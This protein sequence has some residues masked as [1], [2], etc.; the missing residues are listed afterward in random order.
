M[1]DIYPGFSPG[2]LTARDWENDWPN[3]MAARSRAFKRGFA[4]GV[5][6]QATQGASP[7]GH[8]PYDLGSAKADAWLS[9]AC[10]GQSHAKRILATAGGL[11]HAA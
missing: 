3:G 4:A 1:T 7:L 11:A 9:G 6:Y 8:P 2:S 5:K 10:C